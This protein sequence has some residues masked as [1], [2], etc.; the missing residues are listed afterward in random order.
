MGKRQENALET[1]RR[2]L[3]AARSLLREKAAD[4]INIEEITSTAGV[5]K[6]SFYTYFKRKEDLI[7]EIAME[8][9]RGLEELA[10]HQSS[11]VYEQLCIY[12]NKSVQIIQ[13]NTLQIAQQWM[14]SVVAPL[15]EERSGM[16]KYHFDLA[17]ITNI[18]ADAVHTGTLR[19]DTPVSLLARDIVN[20]YYGAVA[21]WCI[22]SG[23]DGDLVSSMA[24]FCRCSL[25]PVIDSYRK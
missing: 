25:L 24:H 18:L 6:G 22:N 19:E 5:A 12:L 10:L 8:E 9:Y 3:E 2:I 11:D 16:A 1:R 15:Q 23:T 7:S 20:A 17:G 4:H 21:V 13:K 14:K